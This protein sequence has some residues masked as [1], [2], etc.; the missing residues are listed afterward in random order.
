MHLLPRDVKFYDQFLSQSELVMKA[1]HVL[2]D[3]TSGGANRLEQ[4][5][6]EIRDLER[7]SDEI[8]HEVYRRLHKTF[9]TPIDP[10]DV[11]AI[12]SGLD[13]ALDGIEAISYGM[14][15]YGLKEVPERVQKLAGVLASYAETLHNI[16]EALN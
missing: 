8:E 3:A 5:A 12:T 16:F 2:R 1:A 11:H 15:A 7:K 10:E 13:Q 6:V 4:A 9:I 14:S